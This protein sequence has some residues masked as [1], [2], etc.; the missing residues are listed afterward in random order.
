MNDEAGTDGQAALGPSYD[1]IIIGSGLGGSS[2]AYRLS[3]LGRKVLLVERGDFLKPDRKSE[4]E[5]VG[6]YLY[7]TVK[8]RLE[9]L[10][11]VGGQTKFYGSALYRMR[12]SDFR[13]VEHENGVSPAWPISYADLEPYYEQAEVL[14][15]VHGPPGR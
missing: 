7:H 4:A 13:E 3:Q 12:E 10:S 2:L 11:Y 1:V 8:D 6:K 5:P 9:P 14:Y 15:R